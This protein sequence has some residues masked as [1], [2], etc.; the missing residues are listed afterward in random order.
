MNI[1]D[2]SLDEVK[3]K[4]IVDLYSAS[5]RTHQIHLKYICGRG[6]DANPAE[7]PSYIRD[8]DKKRGKEGRKGRG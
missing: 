3:A 2:V 8:K 4:V 5:S 7:P 1:I 6:S